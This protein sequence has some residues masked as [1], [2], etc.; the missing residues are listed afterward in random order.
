MWLASWLTHRAKLDRKKCADRTYYHFIDGELSANHLSRQRVNS[1]FAN[2]AYFMNEENLQKYRK[3]THDNN[4]QWSYEQVA[5]RLFDQNRSSNFWS[6]D[7]WLEHLQTPT[8]QLEERDNTLFQWEETVRLLSPWKLD[9]SLLCDDIPT[10]II[11][12]EQFTAKHPRSENLL[13][14]IKQYTQEYNTPFVWWSYET[15]IQH[16]IDQWSMVILDERWDPV[17]REVQLS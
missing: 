4:L 16:Y 8:D 6:E 5:E 1:T 15:I 13:H 11:L 7:D 9:E 2:K 10:I 17:Y 14:F 12:D 3:W